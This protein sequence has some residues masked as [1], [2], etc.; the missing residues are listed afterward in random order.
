MNEED[1]AEA[2]NELI[3]KL[4]GAKGECVASK[5]ATYETAKKHAP[6]CIQILKLLGFTPKLINKRLEE[7]ISMT[8]GRSVFEEDFWSNEDMII[9]LSDHLQGVYG[10]LEEF[11]YG[12]ATKA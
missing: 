12:A 7:R 3:E 6:L 11:K 5:I 8:D 1:K 10:P 2:L 9:A 4:K